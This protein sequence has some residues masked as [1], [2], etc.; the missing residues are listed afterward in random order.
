M[1]I[2][3]KGEGRM[4]RY[5]TGAMMKRLRE[6]R[7]MTQ[8]EFAQKLNVSD[9]AV[10][11]W[12]TGKGYPDI[13][14]IEPIAEALGISVMELLSGSD[15]KNANRSFN[16]L[17]S[18]LTVCPICGNV[19]F[20]TGAAVMSCCG[21]TLQQLEAEEPDESHVMHIENVE[22]EY[23]VTVD[24]EMSKTHSISFLAALSDQGI[25]IVKLYPEGNAE[26]RFK[27]SRT[28]YILCYCNR[29]GLFKESV[30]RK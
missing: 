5:V 12:E 17:R 11:K 28:R 25:E 4:D 9:K 3:K 29:H 18:Q 27:R 19:I 21:L 24:H 10:S 6:E 13:T 2:Q 16:M 1:L 20:S 7:K 15:V 23:Y 30:R 26:A 22:D 8:A 14:L